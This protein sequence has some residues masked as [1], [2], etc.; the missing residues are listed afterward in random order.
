MV[1]KVCLL[2]ATVTPRIGKIIKNR[3]KGENSKLKLLI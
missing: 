1:S 2:A 3:L